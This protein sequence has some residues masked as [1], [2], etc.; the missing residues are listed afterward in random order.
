MLFPELVR[1]DDPEPH[2]AALN[3]AI[4]EVLLRT[5]TIPLLRTYRW[6]RPSVSFGYFAKFA[7][8]ERDW[9]E[10]EAVRRWTGGGIV[11]HGEDFTYSLLI[12]HDCAFFKMRTADS[13]RAIHA[14]LATALGVGAEAL[15]PQP[16][17]KVSAACFANAARHDVVVGSTKVAGAAQRRTRFGLLHQGSIQYPDLPPVFQNLLADALG[18]RIEQ[19]KLTEALILEATALAAEKYGTPTWLRRA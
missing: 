4:D 8:I 19:G 11:A 3:M 5:A 6:S 15:A 7:E 2:P 1:L 9:P 10:R 14:C 17:P 18:T 16:A 13:Y 12:P